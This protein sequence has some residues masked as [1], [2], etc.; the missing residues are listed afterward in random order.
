[1]K[2]CYFCTNN[3]KTVDYKDVESLKKFID[4]LARI[5]SRRKSGTCAKH[6]RKITMSIKR[7]RFLALLP[8]I[9]R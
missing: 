5:L 9:G 2:Q 1:M 6:Q 4:P 3:I 7:A 8:F